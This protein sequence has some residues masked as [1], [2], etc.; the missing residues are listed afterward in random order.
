[1]GT[2]AVAKLSIFGDMRGLLNYD[3]WIA[4]TQQLDKLRIDNGYE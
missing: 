1:M 2:G 4:K 3:R